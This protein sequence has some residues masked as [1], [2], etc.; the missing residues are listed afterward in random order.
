MQ[1]IKQNSGGSGER[2]TSSVSLSRSHTGEICQQTPASH[3]MRIFHFDCCWK[4][5]CESLYSHSTKQNSTK[6]LRNKG[7]FPPVE[8]NMFAPCV[9][10]KKPH[11]LGVVAVDTLCKG[12]KVISHWAQTSIQ[13]LL[14]QCNSI[15][16]AWK[17]C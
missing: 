1:N 3:L 2:E 17:Q 5:R 4:N 11:R 6:H 13:R 14:V 12:V 10:G 15:E 16:M 7:R 8:Q 9:G